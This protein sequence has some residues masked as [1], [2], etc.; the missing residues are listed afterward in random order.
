MHTEGRD[1]VMKETITN[2]FDVYSHSSD[3]NT[4]SAELHEIDNEPEAVGKQPDE[5]EK[6]TFLGSIDLEEELLNSD[7]SD[8]GRKQEQVKGRD[9]EKTLNIYDDGYVKGWIVC[10]EGL[11]AGEDFSLI[12]D[13]TWVGSGPDS[14][15]RIASEDSSFDERQFMMVYDRSG[16]RHRAEPSSAG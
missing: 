5:D 13:V 11:L 16:N 6:T 9:D 12:R 15:L 8:D 10:I 1:S 4:E 3:I 14:D 7:F 2:W